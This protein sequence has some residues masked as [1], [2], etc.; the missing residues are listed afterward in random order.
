M[1]SRVTVIKLAAPVLFKYVSLVYTSIVNKKYRCTMRLHLP[2]H[3][4]G[5]TYTH[6]RTC[7]RRKQ[8]MSKIVNTRLTGY[9]RPP[10]EQNFRFDG[11]N[12]FRH[13]SLYTRIDGRLI[14]QNMKPPVAGSMEK[15]SRVNVNKMW[16][17]QLLRDDAIPSQHTYRLIEA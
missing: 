2:I 14:P 6:S 4:V 17:Y 8:R 1:T 12:Q 3:Y 7:V 11:G 9:K 5:E 13:I 10:V 16:S 15:N